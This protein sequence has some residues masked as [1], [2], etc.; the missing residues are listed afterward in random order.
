MD[1]THISGY[2][3]LRAS[4]KTMVENEQSPLV[5]MY[6]DKVSQKVYILADST[7]V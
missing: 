3:G 7:G 4:A 6:F 1:S 5:C 2:D